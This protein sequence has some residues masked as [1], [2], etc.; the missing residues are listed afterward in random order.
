M[1]YQKIKQALLG[2]G[3]C[4]SCTSLR[5]IGIQDSEKRVL[6][7]ETRQYIGISDPDGGAYIRLIG[8][9]RATNTQGL[10]AGCADWYDLAQEFRVVIFDPAGL[11]AMDLADNFIIDLLSCSV[12]DPDDARELSFAVQAVSLDYE[13]IFE[14]ETGAQPERIEGSLAAINL[15]LSMTVTNCKPSKKSCYV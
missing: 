3:K 8:D 13:A 4:I 9:L 1:F 7:V 5:S 11:P 10:G 14:D 12:P 6:D 2:L 15:R